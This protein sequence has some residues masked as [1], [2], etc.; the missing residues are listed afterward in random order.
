MQRL[1]LRREVH[2]LTAEGRLSAYILG[3]LPLILGIFIFSINR[4]YMQVLFQSTVGKALLIG[5]LLLQVVGFYWM[6][7]IVDIET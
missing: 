2:S 1:R 4:S 5:G 3:S 6:Y 7:R